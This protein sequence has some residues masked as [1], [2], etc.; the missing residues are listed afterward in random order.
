M[1]KFQTQS[2]SGRVEF[3]PAVLGHCGG[4][5]FWLLVFFRMT[6]R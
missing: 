6:G 4:S 2:P 5:F 1:K 3:V